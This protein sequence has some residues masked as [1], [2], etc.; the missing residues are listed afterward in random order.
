MRS[1]SK[2]SQMFGKFITV[3]VTEPAGPQI[4]VPWV[5]GA[6]VIGEFVVVET[7]AEGVRELS[8][9]VVTVTG[10]VVVVVGAFVVVVVEGAIVV[11]VYGEGVGIGPFMDSYIVLIR[12]NGTF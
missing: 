9:V 10:I 2:R 6:G 4:V 12:I 1:T 5:V 11:V 3:V 7:T 8:L